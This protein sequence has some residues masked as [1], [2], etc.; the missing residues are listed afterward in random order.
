M[1]TRVSEDYAVTSSEWLGAEILRE[2]G[3][4]GAREKAK[5]AIHWQTSG[6]A[7][8]EKDG[9]VLHATTRIIV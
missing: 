4:S 8:H 7:R 3:G 6:D 1:M 5:R 2:F 9:H